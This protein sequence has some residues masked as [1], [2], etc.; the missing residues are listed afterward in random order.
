MNLEILEYDIACI[1]CKNI[2]ENRIS[3]IQTEEDITD[4]SFWQLAKLLNHFKEFE[5]ENCGNIGS[6]KVFSIYAND[7]NPL[8]FQYRIN[9][10]RENGSLRINEISKS[11]ISE[12]D[13]NIAHKKIIESLKKRTV[14]EKERYDSGNALLIVDFWNENEKYDITIRELSNWGISETELIE[15]FEE[16]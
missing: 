8:K 5:C 7:R 12:I 1:K 15:L 3:T 9:V 11:E 13:K 6:W 4:F 14:L 2:Q 16:K 10:Y